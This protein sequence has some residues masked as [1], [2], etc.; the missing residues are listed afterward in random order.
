[1]FGSFP[2]LAV[3]V[4]AYNLLAFLSS[5]GQAGT[6]LPGRLVQPTGWVQLS[7]GAGWSPTLSDLIL[8]VAIGAFVVDLAKLFAAG[9]TEATIHI[10]TSLLLFCCA[11][12]FLLLPA[13]ATST[14]ALLSLMSVLS[15]V[16][17]L[18][19]ALLAHARRPEQG[20]RSES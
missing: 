12:E 9:K 10:W 6:N 20:F 14:F 5:D 16:A 2:M 7:S 4:V 13:F 17:G 15:V 3:P 8:A 11:I 1:M 19:F 18:A